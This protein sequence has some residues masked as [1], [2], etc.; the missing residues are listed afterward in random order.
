MQN[1]VV[2]FYS[3]KY[4]SRM[5]FDLAYCPVELFKFR[6]TCSLGSLMTTLF[7]LLTF[8]APVS[9]KHSQSTRAK[10]LLCTD[11]S[12]SFLS[13]WVGFTLQS[14]IFI[15]SPSTPAI[16]SANI[17]QEVFRRTAGLHCHKDGKGQSTEEQQNLFGLLRLGSCEWDIETN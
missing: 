5:Q 11:W 8:K 15:C 13:F 1:G 12:Q 17:S 14:L 2:I 16:Y 6:S 4:P 9:Q 10:L 7:N 3:R